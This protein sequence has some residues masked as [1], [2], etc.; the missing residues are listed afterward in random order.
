MKKAK[1]LSLLGARTDQKCLE[2]RGSNMKHALNRIFIRGNEKFAGILE[3]CWGLIIDDKA[4][5]S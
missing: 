1:I 5:V 3:P 4:L 2:M